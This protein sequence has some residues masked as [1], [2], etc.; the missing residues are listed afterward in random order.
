MIRPNRDLLGERGD[1]VIALEPLALEVDQRGLHRA[2]Q[3]VRQMR[4][5]R[6][7]S[8]KQPCLSVVVT[9][10]WVAA[11]QAQR[12]D[13]SRQLRGA[14]R[15]MRFSRHPRHATAQA[16]S[17]VLRSSRLTPPVCG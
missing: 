4:A 15:L 16:Q 5:I 14:R 8:A 3:P 1:P 6:K 11:P 10:G 13:R 17:R 2:E 9:V 12:G 7:Q